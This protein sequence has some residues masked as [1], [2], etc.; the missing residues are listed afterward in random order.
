M[1]DKRRPI[2]RD[3][4]R[5]LRFIRSFVTFDYDLRKPLPKSAKKKITKY[6]DH[7]YALHARANKVYRT[8]NPQKLAKVQKMERNEADAFPALK[9][10]FIESSAANP[11]EKVFFDKEGRAHIARKFFE[12]KFIEFDKEALAT[13]PDEEIERALQ[14]EPPAFAYRIA[15]DIYSIAS[16][17]TRGRIPGKIK[18]LQTRYGMDIETRVHKDEA[19]AE[20]HYWGNWLNGLIP[21]YVRN[22][23][24]LNDFLIRDDRERNNLKKARRAAKMRR[25]RERE[26]HVT[27]R[28]EYTHRVVRN[29]DDAEISRHTSRVLAEKALRRIV[30]M[31]RGKLTAAAFRIETIK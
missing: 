21:M 17:A 8:R 25:Y 27:P 4:S 22:Q 24:E 16:T 28:G 9:V 1:P 6:F 23:S 2:N 15:A 14:V 29:S 7:V 26:E 30:S 31:S 12:M 19:D 18:E 10:A 20:N 13:E 11:V 3:Y 5:K